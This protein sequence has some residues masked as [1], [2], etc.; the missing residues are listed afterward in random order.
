[1]SS[2]VFLFFGVGLNFRS[3]NSQPHFAPSTHTPLLSTTRWGCLLRFRS[4]FIFVFHMKITK[5]K[6]S[7]VSNRHGYNMPQDTPSAKVELPCKLQSQ[8]PSKNRTNQQ[9]HLRPVECGEFFGVG[10]AVKIDF[11]KVVNGWEGFF[12]KDNPQCEPQI[13]DPKF[14]NSRSPWSFWNPSCT[15]RFSSHLSNSSVVGKGLRF[16]TMEC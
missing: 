10:N 16:G 2:F 5:D 11:F 3:N 8:R 9:P 13:I 6:H 15:G 12:Q 14:L 4:S 7:Q 1:M